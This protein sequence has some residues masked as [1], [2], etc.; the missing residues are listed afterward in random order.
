MADITQDSFNEALN[1]FKIVFQRGRDIRDSELNE[2]QD[3]L[4]FLFIRSIAN[5]VQRTKLNTLNPGS[6]DDGYLVVGAGAANSVTLKAGTLFCDGLGIKLSADTP[7]SGF[8]TN[9]GPGARTDVVYLAITEAEVADPSASPQLGETTKRRQIQVTVN[10]ST[11]GDA[12]VPANTGAEIFAGGIHYFK[13]ASINRPAGVAAINSGDVTDR[14]AQLPPQ[15]V[16]DLGLTTV[17]KGTALIGYS[18]G[19]AWL[20]GTTNP[21]TTLK[22]QLDKIVTDL[23]STAGGS[24]GADHVGADAISGTFWSLLAGS[25]S[26]QI[27]QLLGHVNQ[28]FA[29]RMITAASS[30]T[31]ADSTIIIDVATNS[32]AYNLQLPNPATVAGQRYYLAARDGDIAAH[33][34][35]LVRFGSELIAGVAANY[36][37]DNPMGAWILESD[38]TDWYVWSC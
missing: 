23:I 20:D 13:I 35:T 7:L 38:G 18:G 36:P 8:T 6:N 29:H 26:A 34:V 4:R 14:R 9:P 21:A 17:G 28:R 19:P 2:F 22:A 24:S 15:F 27:A 3:I 30:I 5:G 25:I 11:T 31:S 1:F 16:E 12:G 33:N 10:I 37:L 32:V